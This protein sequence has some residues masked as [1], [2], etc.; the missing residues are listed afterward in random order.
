[1][2]LLAELKQVG[3][4]IK[5]EIIDNNYDIV[6]IEECTC[7]IDIQ[8]IRLMMWIYGDVKSWFRVYESMSENGSLVPYIEFKTQK[9]RLQAYRKIKEYKKQNEK[10]LKQLKI[11]ELEEQLK[12]L[13]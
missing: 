2:N 3:E 5:Q 4:K 7:T 9:E 13:K 6:K 12:K 11:K 1:M 8:G 10:K